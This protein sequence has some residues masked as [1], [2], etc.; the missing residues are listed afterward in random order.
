MEFNINDK[1]KTKL[2]Q[3]GEDLLKLHNRISYDNNYNKKTKILDEQL[4]VI[5]NPFGEHTF[6]GG[7]NYFVKNIFYIGE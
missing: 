5:M 6:N 1:I 7:N 2:T 3:H 4:W